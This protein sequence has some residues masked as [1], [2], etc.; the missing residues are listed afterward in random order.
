VVQI[1]ALGVF[2]T[3]VASK[4]LDV[5]VHNGGKV[6]AKRAQPSKSQIGRWRGLDPANDTSD[7]QVCLPVE[8]VVAPQR[9]SSYPM[10]VHVGG[11]L[12]T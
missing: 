11:Y 2:S 6:F 12:Y 10:L 8:E 4:L 1:Q 7:D 9:A 3:A 5:Q